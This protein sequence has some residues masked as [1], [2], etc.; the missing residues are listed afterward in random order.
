MLT[1][2]HE[3]GEILSVPFF[4]GRDFVIDH[5]FD[6]KA[7]V[8][9]NTEADRCNLWATRSSIFIC[10]D[11]KHTRTTSVR[12]TQSKNVDKKRKNHFTVV[13]FH[14]FRNNK[15]SFCRG[16]KTVPISSKR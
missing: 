13:H 4:P 14:T 16:M 2:V 11:E 1:E 15:K 9:P 3:R 12:I 10:Y 7:F 6:A 5:T 8:R